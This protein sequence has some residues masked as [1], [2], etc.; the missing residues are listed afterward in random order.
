M[1]KKLKKCLK[2]NQDKKLTLRCWL[3][4]PGLE[5]QTEFNSKQGLTIV[6]NQGQGDELD[7]EEVVEQAK[8]S[9]QKQDKPENNDYT[10]EKSD[11]E[12]AKLEAQIKTYY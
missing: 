2:L 9:Q 12:L 1:P 4:C 5:R 7:I 8:K 11:Q 3:F 10:E 6:P